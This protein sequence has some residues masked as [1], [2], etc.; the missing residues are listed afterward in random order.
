MTAVCSLR[1]GTPGPP[2]CRPPPSSWPASAPGSCPT[3]SPPASTLPLTWTVSHFTPSSEGLQQWHHDSNHIIGPSNAIQCNSPCSPSE[4][5][6]CRYRVWPVPAGGGP[7]QSDE[8]RGRQPR[9]GAAHARA[10]GQHKIFLPHRPDIFTPPCPQ[11]PATPGLP[12]TPNTPGT[13]GHKSPRQARWVRST[14][15]I[16]HR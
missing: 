9:Q 1:A 8:R 13:Q 3:P 11:G 15:V 2:P 12:A 16:P 5:C 14:T 7:P 10:A 4:C 6:C